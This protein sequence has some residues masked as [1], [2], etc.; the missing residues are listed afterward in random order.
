[1]T[2]GFRSLIS[3]L[4]PALVCASVSFAQQ[5]NDERKDKLLLQEL[6]GVWVLESMEMDGMKREGD[7]L[8]PRF[9]GMKQS[10]KGDRMTVL[11][12]DGKK[13]E[14]VLTVQRETEPKQIDVVSTDDKGMSRT[15]KWIYK[16]ADG[17]LV[18]AEGKTTRPTSFKTGP[19]IRT[20][21]STFKL[22]R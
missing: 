9:Q 12:T 21:V 3:C 17:K 22:N 1:M 18:I 20:R 10:I 7:A 2:P 11:R 6:Q 13:Y 5:G 19:K 14:C 4:M 15:L 16:V 8:P